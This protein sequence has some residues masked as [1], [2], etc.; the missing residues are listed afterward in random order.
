MVSSKWIEQKASHIN[1]T[2]REMRIEPFQ[3]AIQKMGGNVSLSAN[4][5][6]NFKVSTC[7]AGYIVYTIPAWPS[8]FFLTCTSLSPIEVQTI[9]SQCTLWA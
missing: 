8:M 5:P 2:I 9:N 7:D 3:V 4:N 6:T 1:T